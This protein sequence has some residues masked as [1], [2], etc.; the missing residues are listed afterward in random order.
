MTPPPARARTEFLG[1][2]FDRMDQEATLEWLFD[3]S[4]SARFAYVVTPNVDH[5]VSLNRDGGD[6]QVRAAYDGADLVLCDSR[7]L[8]LLARWSGITLPLV[9]GSDLTIRILERAQ[10]RGST[11]IAVVG[12]DAAMMERLATLF[13]GIGWHQHLPPMGVRRNAAAQAA[14]AGFVE[15]TGADVVLLAI[16]APQSEL[17]CAKIAARGRARGVALCIGASLEFA[18][19]VKRRAPVILQR[20]KLEWLHRLLSEP[21]RLWRRYLVE[22]PKILPLWFRWKARRAPARAAS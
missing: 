12:G 15:E 13:P 18:T 1:L 2:G 14:I 21:R 17:V 9:T 7:I 8:Q 16:G 20:L 11:T 4:R 10:A 5:M 6:P 19:G 22:G 3:T